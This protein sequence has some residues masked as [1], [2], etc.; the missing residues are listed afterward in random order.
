MIGF[1]DEVNMHS[2]MPWIMESILDSE[3]IFILTT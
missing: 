1:P 3:M 2:Q